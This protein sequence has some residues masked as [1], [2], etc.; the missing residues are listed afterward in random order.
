MKG[1]VTRNNCTGENAYTKTGDCVMFEGYPTGLIITGK[2]ALFSADPEAF[3]AEIRAAVYA[4]SARRAI[5]LTGGVIGTMSNSGGDLKTSQEGW[6][7]T[8]FT[9]LNELREDYTI[10]KGGYC[11]YKQLAKLNYRD[12]RVFKID[13]TGM[14]F[15]TIVEV[16]GVDKIRGYA[17]HL[18]SSHRIAADNAGATL[19]SLIY[20]SNFQKEDINTQAI[21]PVGG[22]IEGLSGLL[23]KRTGAGKAKVI[24]SCSATDITDTYGAILAEP[25]LYK[26]KSGENP[27]A[28]DYAGGE[29]EFTPAGFYRIV[30]ADALKAKGITGYEGENAYV[31]L[32]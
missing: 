22:D 30:D 28:V 21:E 29:L 18:G 11:L 7:G 24:T 1:F 19:L 16:E 20:S 13:N 10:T 15:G 2:D 26:N 6:G 4:G 14:I 12:L 31:N 5:P 32:G 23:L 27:T 25:G 3:D 9:G 8:Q 17:V